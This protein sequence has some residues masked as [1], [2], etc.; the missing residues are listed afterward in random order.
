MRLNPLTLATLATLAVLVAGTA[1]A[2]AQNTAK[3]ERTTASGIAITTL[4]AGKGEQPKASDTVKVH[5]RGTLVDGKEFDSSYKRGQPT[6]FPLQRV[7]PCWTEGVQTMKVGEKAR[8]VCPSKLAYGSRGIPGT[9]PPDAT[10][11][12]EVELLEILR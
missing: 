10:L 12:F 5:Y 6:S 8:L 4:Q 1:N 7:I 3:A 9:I 2:N 11:V